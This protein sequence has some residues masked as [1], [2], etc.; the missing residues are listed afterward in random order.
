MDLLKIELDGLDE[1]TGFQID[2]IFNNNNE[3]PY[4]KKVTTPIYEVTQ[5]K[6]SIDELTDLNKTNYLK[7][8]IENSNIEQ[9][10]KNFLVLSSYRHL[11][12]NYSKIAEYYAHSNEE[13]QEIMEE[14]ALVIIDYDKAIEFGFVR[15]TE[16]IE[17]MLEFES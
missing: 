8:I 2:E 10:I 9:E 1:F 12:F 17:E 13:V 7:K 4:S 6:P 14:L 5:N 3:N 11:K 15:I 16:T